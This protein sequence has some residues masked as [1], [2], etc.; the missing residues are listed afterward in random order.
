MEKIEE[1]EKRTEENLHEKEAD[2]GKGKDSFLKDSEGNLSMFLF[3]FYYIAAQQI[4][5][6]SA[7]GTTFINGNIVQFFM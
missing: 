4:E 1:K 6:L 7:D 2:N 5:D 3:K